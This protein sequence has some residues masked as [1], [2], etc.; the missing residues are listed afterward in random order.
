MVVA[1]TKRHLVLLLGAAIALSSSLRAELL[2]YE[3]FDPADPGLSLSSG[4]LAGATSRGFATGSF[5]EVAGNDDY[6]ADF[7]SDGLSMEGLATVGGSVQVG[8]GGTS[9]TGAVNVYRGSGVSVPPGGTIYGSFL[10]QNN[11]VLSRYLTSLILE[12]GEDLP[13]DKGNT[14]GA[15]R[16]ADNDAAVL[17]AFSPDSFARDEEGEPGRATQGIKIAKYPAH[18]SKEMAQT[19]YDLPNG[20]TFLVV[21]SIA[22]TAGAESAQG[23]G[24][25]AVMW[26]LSPDNLRAIRAAGEATQETVDNNHLVRVVVD[27]GLRGR[28]LDT[29]FINIAATIAGGAKPSSSVYDE[30]RIGTDVAS[31]L[32]AP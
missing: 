28:L 15:H 23:G 32:P 29:D 20:E 1:M 14:R 31:V 30:I 13:D 18:G 25:Q 10:F 21:W 12:T 16:V 26:I 8:V 11:Q 22:N 19:D 3:G 7:S 24:Q 6:N 5:W 9:R 27:K 2:V 17:V 4:Q